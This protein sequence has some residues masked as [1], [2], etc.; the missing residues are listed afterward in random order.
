MLVQSTKDTIELLPSL[1]ADWPNGEIK[2]VLARGGFEVDMKW[3]NG[4]PV[5]VRVKSLCGNKTTL[6]FNGSSRVI[7]LK[8]GG[9]IEEITEF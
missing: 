4:V 1:P 9:T 2:G 3:E 6:V 5:N 7:N 8:K